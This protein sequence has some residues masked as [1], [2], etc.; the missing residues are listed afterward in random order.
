VVNIRVSKMD[1]ELYKA[2]EGVPVGEK[3]SDLQGA[4]AFV[5]S[6]TASPW[7]AAN[8]SARPTISVHSTKGNRF[9]A[10]GLSQLV[11]LHELAH[12]VT[13]ARCG[14][15]HSH[16]AS[17]IF[18]YLELV[19]EFLPTSLAKLEANL[20]SANLYANPAAGQE[21]KARAARPLVEDG[22]EWVAR[23]PSFETH[24]TIKEVGAA[25]DAAGKSGSSF[26]RAMGGDRCKNPPLAWYWKPVY[27]SG[28]RWL[29]RECLNH[30][31][32]LTPARPRRPRNRYGW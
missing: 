2:Q 22:V 4:K 20:D 8:M 30:L 3:F 10:W 25:V 9:P 28:V 29:P 1:R 12:Q 6:V 14:N 23:M 31:D 32:D 18:W 5:S 7:W 21:N 15:G 13:D 27:A 19:K 16:D 17:Y 24:A 11:V 26:V